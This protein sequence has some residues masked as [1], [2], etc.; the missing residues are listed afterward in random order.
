MAGQWLRSEVIDMINTIYEKLKE[1]GFPVDSFFEDEKFFGNIVIKS[2]LECGMT[3]SMLKDRGIWDCTVLLKDEEIPIVAVVYLLNDKSFD[4]EELSFNTD[5][6]LIE[7]LVAQKSIL[8]SLTEESIQ[9]AEE[10]WETLTKERL[11][12]MMS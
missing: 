10:K 8:T 6:K 3:I 9:R 2:R 11:K 1:N 4:F 5:E 7:W 12:N